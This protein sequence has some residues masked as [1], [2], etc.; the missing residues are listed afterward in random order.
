MGETAARG[1]LIFGVNSF[2]KPSLL[3]RWTPRIPETGPSAS[4]SALGIMSRGSPF[5]WLR[6][7]P[8]CG[9]LRTGESRGQGFLD[10]GCN[11]NLEDLMDDAEERSK[12]DPTR[13]YWSGNGDHGDWQARGRSLNLYWPW[14]A[15]FVACVLNRL[16]RE[17]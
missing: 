14:L 3:S 7:V 6:P 15:R 2:T 4:E 16:W 11:L 12:D 1:G 5:G 8:A 9:N 13:T 10:W 17:K